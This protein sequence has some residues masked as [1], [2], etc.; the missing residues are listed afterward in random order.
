M[1]RDHVMLSISS[2]LLAKRTAAYRLIV[3]REDLYLY[4]YTEVHGRRD[5]KLVY[6][7]EGLINSSDFI[8]IIYKIIY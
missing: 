1:V 6:D 4:R 3:R 2:P 5:C 7:F 8:S